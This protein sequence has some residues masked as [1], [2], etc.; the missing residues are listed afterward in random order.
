[1]R[2]YGSPN[3]PFSTRV[4]IAARV[5]GVTLELPALP[6]G[7]LRSDE[8]LTLNPVAKIPVLVTEDGV[9]I[10]ESEVILRYLEDRFPEPSLMPREADERARV[11]LAVRLMDVY[12]MTPVIR[13][14]AHLDPARR[15]PRAVEDEV[16]RWTD[17]AAYLA[18]FFGAGLP[19]APAG[20][21]LA[22]C[23]L[24]PCLHLNIRIAAMLGLLADPLRR[25]GNLAGYYA[26]IGKDPV[27]GPALDEL[28]ASQT[29]YDERA[30]RPSV[31]HWHAVAP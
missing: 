20:L 25:H 22:D 17:G 27:V 19:P 29:A 15:D 18:H 10:P 9:R 31:A 21:S 12:V 11:N 16:A 24:A 28:T 1:M 6:A 2:L 30:G 5:K 23:A 13:L 26:A 7:G 14:F 3:S 4:R 8:F